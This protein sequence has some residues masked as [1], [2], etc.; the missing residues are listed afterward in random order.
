MR[1]LVEAELLLKLLDE[2]RVESLRAAVLGDNGIRGA[3]RLHA[4]PRDFAAAAGNA[5]RRRDVVAGELRDH[6]FHRAARGE[7]N[8]HE[9]YEEDPE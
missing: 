6:A 2:L 5:R 3:C 8:D 9:R 1:R 7:L 4:R